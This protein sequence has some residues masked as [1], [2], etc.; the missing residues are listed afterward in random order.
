MGAVFVDGGADCG[1]RMTQL[2][3]PFP[4]WRQTYNR[5]YY[6]ANRARRRAQRLA[7]K[8]GGSFRDYLRGCV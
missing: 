1:A 7:S 5:S 8:W 4:S 6:A 2:A 3:L